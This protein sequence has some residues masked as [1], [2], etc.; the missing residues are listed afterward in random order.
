MY[1]YSFSNIQLNVS[2]A[3]STVSL[4]SGWDL[5]DMNVL[6]HIPVK[7]NGDYCTIDDILSN[8][9]NIHGD[10]VNILV[11]VRNVRATGFGPDGCKYL[12]NYLLRNFV[13]IKQEI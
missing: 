3:Y 7:E 12:P 1:S 8:G 9:Q 10:L 4:Y 5:S 2:E 6:M 11:A 13:E